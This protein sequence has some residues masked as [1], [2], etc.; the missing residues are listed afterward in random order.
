MNTFGNMAHVFSTY[1]SFRSKTDKTPFMRGIN[2]IQLFHDGKRWWIINVFWKQESDD[3]P[4]PKKYLP[5][6]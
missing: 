5:K 4:I 6:T 1:E 3:Q 2:S